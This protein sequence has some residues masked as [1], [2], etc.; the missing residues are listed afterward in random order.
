MSAAVAL[1]LVG[2]YH[3][4]GQHGVPGAGGCLPHT[5][6][7]WGRQMAGVYGLKVLPCH[8]RMRGELDLHPCRTHFAM[9]VVHYA[10]LRQGWFVLVG[11][12]R[13]NAI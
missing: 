12:G 1:Y 2:C 8:G 3:A 13:D 6:L 11:N 5:V 4:W 10:G 9:A 7:A